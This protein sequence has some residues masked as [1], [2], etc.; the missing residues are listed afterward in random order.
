MAEKT[1][2]SRDGGGDSAPKVV[3]IRESVDN[4]ESV[5]SGRTQTVTSTAP[6]PKPNTTPKTTTPRPTAGK[7]QK[8]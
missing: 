1:S 6:E 4:S 5:E 2:D 3:S 8:R 7:D